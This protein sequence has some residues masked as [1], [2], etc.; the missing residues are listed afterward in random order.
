MP[1]SSFLEKSIPKKKRVFLN[2]NKQIKDVFQKKKYVWFEPKK[3]F[4][5][6]NKFILISLRLTAAAFFLIL[7]LN[8]R[9]LATGSWQNNKSCII[10]SKKKNCWGLLVSF[11][12]L[13]IFIFVPFLSLSSFAGFLVI[14]LQPRYLFVF[15][16]RG[17]VSWTEFED[18]WPKKASE[19]QQQSF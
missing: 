11:P 15:F 17:R 1:F 7:I 6:L 4:L 14:L 9:F 12:C 16:C 10:F 13:E 2:L 8:L 3:V 19:K 5:L 18:F